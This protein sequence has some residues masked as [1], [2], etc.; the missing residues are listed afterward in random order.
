[1]K[2]PKVGTLV[3]GIVAFIVIYAI[4]AGFSGCLNEVSPLDVV[5]GLGGGATEGGRNACSIAFVVTGIQVAGW[6]L[7]LAGTLF[8][9]SLLAFVVS[10]GS[11]IG[12]GA[13]LANGMVLGWTILRDFINLVFIGALIYAAISLILRLGSAKV[14]ELIVRIL[15][16]ALLVNFSFFFG[17]AVIDAS[18]FVSQKIYQEAIYDG[19]NVPLAQ[20]NPFQTNPLSFGAVAPVS[21]RFLVVTR[22]GSLYDLKTEDFVDG[23]VFADNGIFPYILSFFG[24]ILFSLTAGVFITAAIFLFI[25]FIIIV[26][27]MVTSPI[28]ILSVTG[29]PALAA[30]GAAWWKTLYAQALF[31]IVFLL[32][33]AVSFKVMELGFVREIAGDKALFDLVTSPGDLDV[34]YANLNLLAVFAIAWFLMFYSLKA[35][36]NVAQQKPFTPPSPAQFFAQTQGIGKWVAAKTYPRILATKIIS[37]TTQEIPGT[38]YRGM[39][40]DKLPSAGR[41]VRGVFGTP[42]EKL[43]VA[44]ENYAKRVA[45]EILKKPIEQQTKEDR[46]AWKNLPEKTREEENKKASGE[47]R[48][49]IAALE[50]GSGIAT[51]ATPLPAKKEQAKE[52]EP[53]K[54]PDET[55][56]SNAGRA[57]SSGAQP[58]VMARVEAALKQ[59]DQAIRTGDQREFA[60]LRTL[61]SNELAQT[62]LAR[63][64]LIADAANTRRFVAAV[65]R[66]KFNGAMMNF[67]VAQITTQVADAV[68]AHLDLQT[69]SALRRRIG[70][71]ERG[72][73]DTAVERDNK[74]VRRLYDTSPGGMFS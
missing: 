52:K 22:L 66:D 62:M 60:T 34:W 71:V 54:K 68:G 50:V 10:M 1:M 56:A 59:V 21:E 23:G 12:K 70:P 55:K 19:G 13:P 36:A 69:Y 48:K 18:N 46:E 45:R 28:G 2:F 9:Y 37:Q 42:E 11:L 26:I 38:L 30:W 65:G 20:L 15:V 24:V 25:R 27:L 63:R 31:P 64:G 43:A 17:A 4:V 40:L 5:K 6:F 74:G 61:T 57:S 47:K 72:A 7:G 53:K 44:R 32:L 35:A 14:G 73:L 41:A 51:G 58:D 49:K 67:P 8:D 16:A 29:I 3:S 39:Y 33:V